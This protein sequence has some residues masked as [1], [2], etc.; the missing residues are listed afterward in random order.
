M[1]VF[2]DT[3]LDPNTSYRYQVI[4]VDSKQ[5]QSIPATI[6]AATSADVTALVLR[7]K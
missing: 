2:I 4:A 5:D 3:G 7:A 6:T 1:L